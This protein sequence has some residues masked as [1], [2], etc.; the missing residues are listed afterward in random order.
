MSP[1]PNCH[2]LVILQQWMKHLCLGQDTLMIEFC[3]TTSG[4]DRR[5]DSLQ[6]IQ[7]SDGMACW[8]GFVRVK[9]ST[10]PYVSRTIWMWSSAKIK[11]D[12]DQTAISALSCSPAKSLL[13]QYLGN[14]CDGYV[15]TWQTEAHPYNP[16]QTTNQNAWLRSIQK[17]D[18]A[19]FSW[20]WI[21]DPNVWFFDIPLLIPFNNAIKSL[22]PCKYLYK[23]I[24]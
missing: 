18:G 22:C 24:N 8:W 10:G 16:K 3:S 14:T 2:H 7:R 11:N 23:I 9:S 4:R 21:D 13:R 15:H 12:H 5:V 1:S 19:I 6:V 17:P 20:G